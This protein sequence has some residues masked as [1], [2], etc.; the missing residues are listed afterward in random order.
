MPLTVQPLKT[1]FI[2]VGSGVAGPRA[3]TEIAQ[4]QR[5]VW[6]LTKDLAEGRLPRW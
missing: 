6:L 1:D 5:G 2:V 4:A 3:A